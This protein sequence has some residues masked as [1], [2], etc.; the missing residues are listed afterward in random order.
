M[1]IKV[2]KLCLS[3]MFNVVPGNPQEVIVPPAEGVAGGGTAYG[4]GDS[5]IHD[6]ITLRGTIDPT[7]VPSTDLVHVWCMPST[8]TVG[9]HDM[10]RPLEPVSVSR[11]SF[12]VFL[13]WC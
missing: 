3:F 1:A 13:A 8:A 7:K 12:L 5:G 10:P 9:P 6:S 4:W 11:I 2:V